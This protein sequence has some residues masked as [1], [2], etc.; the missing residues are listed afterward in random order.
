MSVYV[1]DTHSLIYYFTGQFGK[2]SRR[3]RRVFEQADRCESFIYIPAV[4]LWEV[5]RLIQLD[6]VDLNEPY[7]TWVAALLARPCFECVPLDE[8]QVIEARK[9][10]FNKDIY[11]SAIVATAKIKDVPLITNDQAITNSGRVEVFW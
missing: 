8:N 3:A 10:I 4:A 5:S 7:E 6:V 1:T 2:L 9:Y 11:D